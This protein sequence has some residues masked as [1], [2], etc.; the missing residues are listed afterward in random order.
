MSDDTSTPA[1]PTPSPDPAPAPAPEPT[2]PSL[3]E[4]ARACEDAHDA[5]AAAK[6][7]AFASQAKA[8]ADGQAM[9]S[10]KDALATAIADLVAAAKAE[11]ADAGL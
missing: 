6:E 9:H 5:H 3:E 8:E 11:G 1:D 2:P 7:K 4:L 10:A